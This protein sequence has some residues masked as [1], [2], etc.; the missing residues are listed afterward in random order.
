MHKTGLG[1]KEERDAGRKAE[2]R[3]QRGSG[4]TFYKDESVLSEKVVWGV[5]PGWREQSLQGRG[6][7]QRDIGLR[8][9]STC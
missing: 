9:E 4:A 7:Q 2:S 3:G 6:P 5:R 1:S 8:L